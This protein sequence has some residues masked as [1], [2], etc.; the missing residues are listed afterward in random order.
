MYEAIVETILLFISLLI[1]VWDSR[2]KNQGATASSSAKST[3]VLILG[4]LFFVELIPLLPLQNLIKFWMYLTW[5]SVCFLWIL[6]RNLT[7]IEGTQSS[8][9]WVTTI[10]IAL[11]E[12]A[13][14]DHRSLGYSRML[15]FGL[16]LP[17]LTIIFKTF[18]I[19]RQKTP[20]ELVSSIGSCLMLL[21]LLA[22]K[23]TD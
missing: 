13:K 4:C 3:P 12:N 11:I 5:Y 18:Q 19:N 2:K 23:M 17:I 7:Y 22:A 8:V 6:Y 1:L 9:I 20:Q 21:A 15:C 14:Q 10:L 16:L